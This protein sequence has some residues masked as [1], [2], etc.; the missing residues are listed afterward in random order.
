MCID[1]VKSQLEQKSVFTTVDSLSNN[2]LF[3]K[4]V[5]FSL[6]SALS[7]FLPLTLVHLFNLWRLLCNL[8]LTKYSLYSTLITLTLKSQ[9]VGW[10]NYH[11]G[12][13]LRAAFTV[14]HNGCS[15]TLLLIRIISDI[16]Q[17]HF[18]TFLY[19]MHSWSICYVGRTRLTCWSAQSN[20]LPI[21]KELQSL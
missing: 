1:L 15:D 13:F 16:P 19:I 7:L 18:S 11:L 14:A 5:I 4:V 12:V 3:Q 10:E 17:T 9:C 6:L 2:T 20:F 8:K 21:C